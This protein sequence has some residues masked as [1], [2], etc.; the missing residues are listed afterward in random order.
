M[1]RTESIYPGGQTA[2]GSPEHVLGL[3]ELVVR[4]LDERRSNVP[5]PTGQQCEGCFSGVT[6]P[7]SF[8]GRK[9]RGTSLVGGGA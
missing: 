5:S 1:N 7:L 8:T 6:K 9:G 2:A 3:H 4:A